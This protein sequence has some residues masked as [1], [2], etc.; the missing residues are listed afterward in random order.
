MLGPEEMSRGEL[1]ELVGTQAV[2][3]EE[4]AVELERLRL[5]VERLKRLIS[6]NSRNSSIPPSTDDLPGRK[7]PA[8]KA[9][10]TAGATKR[11]RGKRPGAAG[12]HLAWVDDA[13]VLDQHTGR[14]V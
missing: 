13:N 12:T 7:K 3:L 9:K 11:K 4:Q 8:R 5:D 1:V 6:R 10:P 14:Y 2:L